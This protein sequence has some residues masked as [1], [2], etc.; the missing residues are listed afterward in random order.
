MS[1]PCA[2]PGRAPGRL[3]LTGLLLLAAGPAP[4]AGDPAAGRALS[5]P[6]QNCHGKDGIGVLPPYPNLAGQSAYY[7]AQQLRAF[8]SGE[9]VNP[10][11]NVVSKLLSDQDIEDLAAYYES[12]GNCAC[13]VAE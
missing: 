5:Q 11:M 4:A 10:N 8:R 6:C 9:R 2:R 1:R 12:L 7:L 13:A 3:L